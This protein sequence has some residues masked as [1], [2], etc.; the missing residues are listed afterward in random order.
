MLDLKDDSQLKAACE[1]AIQHSLALK[2]NQN[3]VSELLALILRVRDVGHAEFVTEEFQR[4][5]WDSNAVASTGMGNVDT[6]SLAI[7]PVIAEHLW[8]LKTQF[9][10]VD[11]VQQDILIADTWRLVASEVALLSKRTPRLKMYRVFA[12]LCPGAFTT[13]AHTRKLRELAKVMGVR[14]QGEPRQA[15]HRMVLDRICAVIGEAEDVFTQE[16]AGRLTLPWLLYVAH[17]QNPE[18]E[19]TEVADPVTGE[20][21]LNP[22]PPERRR[23]GMLAIGGGTATIQ[24]MIE[25]AVDGCSREDFIEHLQSISPMSKRSTF[26]TQLNALIAEWGVLRAQSGELHLTPR[27]EAFLESGDPGDVI[28]WMITRVLGFDYLLS[29]LHKAP[30]S[31]RDAI[32]VLRKVNPGWASDFA[33]TSL[34]NWLRNLQ[35]VD[36]TDKVL[37]LTSEGKEWVERIH[38]P[39]RGLPDAQLSSTTH[40][41]KPQL[42]AANDFATRPSLKKI[43]E[44]FDSGIRFSAELI[45]QLD[46]GLWSHHRRHFAVLTGLSGSGKTQLARG[47]ALSLWQ[48]MDQPADGLLIVPVQPGWH[49]PSSLLGYVNPLD[50]ETYVRTGVLDFLLQASADP[51]RPYT[52]VLDE[53]NLSHPEQYLAP[54]LSAM[55]TGDALE[56]HA[57]N[58]DVSDVPSCLPYP[59]NLLIIGTVNMDETTHGLS[60]KV[61]DRASVIEFWDID[62]SSFPGWKTSALTADKVEVVQSVMTNLMLELRPVRLHFGWRTLHDVIGYVQEA[63][64]GGVIEFKRALDQAIYSKVLPKLRGEDSPRLQE[65]FRKVSELL[66]AAGLKSASLK[67]KEMREDLQHSGSARFWR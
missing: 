64:R 17:V 23:R 53:M 45:G 67:V 47:Y 38:W 42:L 26:N 14:L 24:A 33:P 43:T 63:E 15:L 19:A 10:A 25:F 49:D 40:V 65:V 2:G 16:G 50:T 20:E 57:Q 32:L 9:A 39:P 62:V 52:L 28:D 21:K 36:S 34:I 29:E 22:L 48:D 31:T 51:S 18:A 58:Q 54:L 59:A 55:E 13:I 4:M 8:Q 6:S 11:K 30:I 12:V 3:W 1:N 27:G 61:L 7:N 66:T 41:V 44:G 60:D 37:T 46:A 35:L 56:L 5:L